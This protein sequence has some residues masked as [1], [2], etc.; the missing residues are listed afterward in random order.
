MQDER[1][2]GSVHYELSVSPEEARQGTAKILSRNG[3]RLQVTIPPGIGEGGTVKLTN[4]MRITDG[5][6]GDI[7][8]S[9]SIK[10]APPAAEAPASGEVVEVNDST[11]DGEVLRASLPVMVD[12][13]APWCGPCRMMGPIVE[14]AAR[15]YVGRF[16]FCKINVDENPDTAARYQAMSIPLLVFFKNGNVVD[17]SLGA[18]PENQLRSKIEAWM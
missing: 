18:V 16:K 4:A 15:T 11:F 8:I 7:L 2:Q 5:Q 9:V 14:K 10:E 1:T 12:F 6:D 3:K 13:W 17:K